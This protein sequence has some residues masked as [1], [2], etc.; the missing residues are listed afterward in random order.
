MEIELCGK[1]Y[2]A[3]HSQWVVT[4]CYARLQWSAYYA[5]LKVEHSVKRIDKFA[6]T[7]CIE[8][9]CH[10]IDC[11]IAAVLVIFECSVLNNWV[12]R[13][14]AVAL[15]ACTHEFNLVLLV[16][17]LRST[18]I[19][20][21]GKVC[22]L[23]QFLAEGTCHLNTFAHYNNVN[24]GRWAFKEY[25]A[26]ISANDITLHTQFIGCFRN[27]AEYRG[28]KQSA[29]FFSCWLI[30]CVFLFVLVKILNLTL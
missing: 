7:G 20:I 29:K 12:A 24:V 30:H 19:G 17:H 3:H 6:E 15:L 11:E 26:N 5:V 21:Y 2:A 8:A 13:V 22:S 4:E 16:F 9:Y 18:E 23:S 14:V 28:V 1:A 10:S 25:I 27:L